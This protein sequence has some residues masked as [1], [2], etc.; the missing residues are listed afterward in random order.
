MGRES[1]FIWIFAYSESMKKTGVRWHRCFN[2][3]HVKITLAWSWKAPTGTLKPVKS[4]PFWQPQWL[5][6]VKG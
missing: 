3:S 6:A 2:V 1:G 4:S 5:K